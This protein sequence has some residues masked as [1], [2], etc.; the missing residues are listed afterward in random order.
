MDDERRQRL[1]EKAREREERRQERWERRRERWERRRIDPLGPIFGALVLIWMGVLLLGVLN[2]EVF[3][4]GPYSLTWTNAWSF[5][6]VGIGALL[7]L[8][9]LLRAI[10]PAYQYGIIGRLI[11]GAFCC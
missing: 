2:P 6:F 3:R 10:I 7:I 1:E 5:F 9:A 8:E 4:L 11:G